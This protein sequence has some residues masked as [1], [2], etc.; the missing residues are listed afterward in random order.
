MVVHVKIT[1][2]SAHSNNIA[3]DTRRQHGDKG[4]KSE[5][6]IDFVLKR[7]DVP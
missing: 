5:S 7:C 4:R 3:I 2:A 1:N 6:T